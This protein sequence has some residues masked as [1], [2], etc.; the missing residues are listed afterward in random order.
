MASKDKTK[1][2]IGAKLDDCVVHFETLQSIRIR[3]LFE[4]LN[5]LLVEGNLVFDKTGSI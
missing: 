4:T 3:S 5:P 2:C 1:R